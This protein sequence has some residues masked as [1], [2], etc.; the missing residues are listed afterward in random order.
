M[1]RRRSKKPV[2]RR[3]R[4]NYKP[5]WNHNNRHNS[6]PYTPP[7]RREEP[8]YPTQPVVSRYPREE[9]E[10][11]LV[12][13][14]ETAP[15]GEGINRQ[16]VVGK[17]A[18]YKHHIRPIE[19]TMDKNYSVLTFNLGVSLEP[20]KFSNPQNIHSGEKL[21]YFQFGYLK[22][23]T[24]E[25]F[26]P[27]IRAAVFSELNQ[28]QHAIRPGLASHLADI[29]VED[30]EYFFD[31]AEEYFETGEVSESRVYK[32]PFASAVNLPEL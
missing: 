11:Q 2:S 4:G 20:E 18:W 23:E 21:F 29:Y 16:V 32:T 31:R 14:I 17:L 7:A 24:F 19:L 15:M 28:L 8:Y 10:S 12:G 26:L 1:G 9:R 22:H 25:S 27:H 30:S 13:I 5:K 3:R 6:R